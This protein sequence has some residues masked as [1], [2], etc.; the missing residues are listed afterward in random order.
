MSPTTDISHSAARR[1]R[2][3]MTYR[4]VPLKVLTIKSGGGRSG[5]SVAFMLYHMSKEAATP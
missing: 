1:W 3:L 2:G 5:P 4:S